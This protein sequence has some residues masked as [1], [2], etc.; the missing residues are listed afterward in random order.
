[1]RSVP[2]GSFE[3][4]SRL[5]SL[6]SAW[7]A[8]R[9]GKRRRSS[10]A[11][12]DLDADTHLCLLHRQLR[13]GEYRPGQYRVFAIRDPKTRIIAAPAL[14]DC[15]VHRALLDDIGP[16]YERGFIDHS[17][18]VCAER[19]PQ[20]A[21]LC[22]LAWTRRYRYRLVLD[23]RRYFASICHERLL[24]LFAH[25][26]RDSQTVALLRSL[27]DAGGAVYRHP[28]AIRVLGLHAAPVAHGCGLPLGGYLSHWSGGLYL[29]GLDHFV[30]R[31]LKVVAYQRYMDDMALFANNAA[32]LER[33]FV[34]IA[35]W[36]ARERG[37]QLKA[38]K[39]VQPTSQPATYLGMRVSRAGV[40]PGRKARRRLQVR[41]R[42][43][44][45]DGSQHRPDALERSLH[46][47]RAVL[48]KI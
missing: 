6:W 13:T 14:R 24:N 12:F 15:V 33:A 18:A 27:L 8:Y 47:Y 40:R 20:R 26:L 37:L 16:T 46:S 32:V 4:L 19:G 11:V 3:R 2:R 38:G 44:R 22:H 31:Q 43:H 25:R 39:G 7:C 34:E 23:V 5:G 29:N 30:K 35:D 9:R 17:Y 10:V 48:L 45:Q 41:L 1:M 21:I 36:L 42:A 28:L